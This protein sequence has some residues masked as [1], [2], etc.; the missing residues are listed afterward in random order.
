M[1]VPVVITTEEAKKRSP[2][3]VSTPVILSPRT[4]RLVI[5]A[6]LSERLG[7]FSNKDLRRN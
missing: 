1:K 4:R 3:L 7:R 2:R 5:F 6:C